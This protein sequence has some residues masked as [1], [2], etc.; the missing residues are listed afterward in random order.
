MWFSMPPPESTST[1][2]G[3]HICK[4][5][6]LQGLQAVPSGPSDRSHHLQGLLSQTV[7]LLRGPCTPGLPQH[8]HSCHVRTLSSIQN[9]GEWGALGGACHDR[10]SG[11][12][13]RVSCLHAGRELLRQRAH[14]STCR[15]RFPTPHWPQ[16]SLSWG[17]GKLVSW[18]RASCLRPPPP[19]RTASPVLPPQPGC[20]S[21]HGAAP[22]STCTG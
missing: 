16:L 6:A 9:T 12:R 5:K 19:P 7:P 4:L 10:V 17:R 21:T 2:G 11:T 18:Q 13:S 14:R 8:S 3:R 15:G 20:I 22:A 1:Q